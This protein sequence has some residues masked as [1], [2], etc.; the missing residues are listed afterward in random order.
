M[1]T[2]PQT[3]LFKISL[4]FSDKNSTDFTERKK[5]QPSFLL[6]VHTDTF[7]T[8]F[9]SSLR[10]KIVENTVTQLFLPPFSSIKSAV[11]NYFNCH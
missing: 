1:K 5:L 2:V 3:S 7:S 8:N 11:I 10:K 6:I 9:P 4:H